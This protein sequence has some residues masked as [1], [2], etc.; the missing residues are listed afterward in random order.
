MSDALPDVIA[1]VA[2]VTRGPEVTAA[3]RFGSLG[4]WSSLAALRLL[5]LV[6]QRCGVSLDLRRYLAVETVGELAEL[7]TAGR[8]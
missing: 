7:I 4:N 6:E 8:R 1:L 3:S 2:Q 5:A